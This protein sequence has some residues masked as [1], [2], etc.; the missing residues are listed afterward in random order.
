MLVLGPV[1]VVTPAWW[2]QPHRL[3][4]LSVSISQMCGSI[5]EGDGADIVM[6]VTRPFPRMFIDAVLAI[7]LEDVR[8]VGGLIN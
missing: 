1:A 6:L 4:E 7:G 8:R 2:E 5:V 3:S